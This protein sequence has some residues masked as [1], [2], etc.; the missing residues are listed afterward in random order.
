MLP[1]LPLALVLAVAAFE[2]ATLRDFNGDG[3][4]CWPSFASLRG[5]DPLHSKYRQA[6]VSV[7]FFKPSWGM[8][9][10]GATC[11]Q[12]IESATIMTSRKQRPDHLR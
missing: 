11:R 10:V 2:A 12:P 6:P 5:H 8:P 1:R 4:I 3:P 9:W 7:N